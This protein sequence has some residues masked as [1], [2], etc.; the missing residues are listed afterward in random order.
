MEFTEIDLI[1]FFERRKAW[2]RV[3]K[4][5]AFMAGKRQN[6]FITPKFSV[7]FPVVL[8]KLHWRQATIVGLEKG[9]FWQVRLFEYA[10]QERR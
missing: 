4:D 8:L 9:K 1:C 5:T 6:R 2:E 7:H 10:V 3:L